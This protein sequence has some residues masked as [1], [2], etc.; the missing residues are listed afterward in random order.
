MN[1]LRLTSELSTDRVDACQDAA[2][3]SEGDGAKGCADPDCWN[4]CAL[5]GNAACDPGEDYLMCPTDCTAP[6]P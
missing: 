3:D 6:P 5:C 4:R 2:L 1:V